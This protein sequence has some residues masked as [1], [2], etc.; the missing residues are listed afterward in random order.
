MKLRD[1][2]G[3]VKNK[4]TDWNRSEPERNEV[5][6]ARRSA[7]NARFLA[8]QTREVGRYIWL[9]PGLNRHERRSLAARI[10][11]KGL[12]KKSSLKM[13]DA[14]I[15]VA[16]F[17]LRETPKNRPAIS[18]RFYVGARNRIRKLFATNNPAY[19]GENSIKVQ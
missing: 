18:R 7:E 19:T 1:I 4:I 17:Q 6:A 13:T 16:K 15:E 9:N 5:T 11:R 12:S 14:E 8:R 10:K 3:K 2:Y